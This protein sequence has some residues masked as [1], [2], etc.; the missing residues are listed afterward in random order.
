MEKK[1]M[2]K[3]N[4]TRNQY[5]RIINKAPYNEA[6]DGTIEEYEERKLRVLNN[7]QRTNGTSN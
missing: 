7:E 4:C 1:Y 2:K 3:Y 6:L 5:R